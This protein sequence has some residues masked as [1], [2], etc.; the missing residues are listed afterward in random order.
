MEELAFWIEL[1]KKPQGV[2]WLRD[3]VVHE[4]AMYVRTFISS[5][6]GGGYVTE[7]VASERMAATLLLTVPALLAAKVMIV[8]NDED[9]T[10]EQDSGQPVQPQPIRSVRN[11]FTVVTPASDDVEEDENESS[12]GDD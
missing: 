7:K 8:E 3:G 10:P 5:M 9:A 1:W 12:T 6:N 11:R 2:F 4:V